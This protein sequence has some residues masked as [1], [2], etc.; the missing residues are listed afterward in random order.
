M[1]RKKHTHQYHRT[2]PGMMRTVRGIGQWSCALPDCSH[3]IPRNMDEPVGK[4]SLCN[5]CM[6][7]FMLDEQNMRFD[8]PICASCTNAAYTGGESPDD[9]ALERHIIRSTIATR[10]G[11][12][13]EEVTESEVDRMVQFNKL[14][15]I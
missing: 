11:R 5:N 3:F 12:A 6:D 1:A 9:L 13:L 8:K 10:T 14:K 7:V 4:M 15:D 2:Y